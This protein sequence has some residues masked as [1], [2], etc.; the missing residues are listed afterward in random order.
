MV[1]PLTFEGIYFTA[2]RMFDRDS[3]GSV[4]ARRFAWHLPNGDAY[5][6]LVLVTGNLRVQGNKENKEK[7]E[8]C[9]L[10]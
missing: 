2:S 4:T 6:T 9:G 10:S 8:H 3:N 1:I 7:L 5:L